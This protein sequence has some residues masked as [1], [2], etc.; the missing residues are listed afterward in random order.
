MRD[1]I[2]DLRAQSVPTGATLLEGGAQQRRIG[3]TDERAVDL[4]R[5]GD[6]RGQRVGAGNARLEIEHA[7]RI[8]ADVELVGRAGADDGAATREPAAVGNAQAKR[9]VE[10]GEKTAVLCA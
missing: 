8:A 1:H 6:Q 3:M 7:Q 10:A 5:A 9:A 2:A 4:M